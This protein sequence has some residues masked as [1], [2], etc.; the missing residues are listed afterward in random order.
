M[1]IPLPP[2][3]QPPRPAPRPI[4]A[5]LRFFPVLHVLSGAVLLFSPAFFVP[6]AFS[7]GL[8]DGEHRSFETGFLVTFVS[9]L[10]M[11][12]VPRGRHR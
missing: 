9:G 3:R 5:V 11:F 4:D 6:L 2:L 1:A 12:F 7:L 8:A 10:F